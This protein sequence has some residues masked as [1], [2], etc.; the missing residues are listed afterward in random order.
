MTGPV[1]VPLRPLPDPFTLPLP[2]GIE[3]E[4]IN[5]L[6]VIQPAL[7]PLMPFFD[8][9]DAIVAIAEV[10]KAIPEALSVPPDPTAIAA[11]L[12]ALANKVGKLLGLVPQVALPRTIVKLIV[13]AI[14]VLRTTRGQLMHLQAM[15]QQLVR[16]VDRA[17]ALGDPLLMAIAACAHANIAQEA[18]NVGKAL[19]GVGKILGLVELFMGLVGGPTVPDLSK[20]DG[21]PLGEIVN[22]LD[23]LVHV[24]EGVRALVPGV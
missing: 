2:G 17:K 6:K 11:K 15:E 22:M 8:M 14:E 4:D 7:T 9:L 5:P 24:L 1:C 19:A 12:P 18:A 21:L 3:L 20:L 16:V 13:L 10:V 23:E